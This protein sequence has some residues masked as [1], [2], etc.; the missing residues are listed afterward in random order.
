MSH[1]DKYQGET[2]KDGDWRILRKKRKESQFLQ[3]AIRTSLTEKVTFEQTA[4]GGKGKYKTDLRGRHTSG[5]G[6]VVGGAWHV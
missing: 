1:G 5:K 6:P 4:G 3:R 2:L